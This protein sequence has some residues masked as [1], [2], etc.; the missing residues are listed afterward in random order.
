PK[1][2]RERPAIWPCWRAAPMSSKPFSY[3]ER[4]TRLAPLDPKIWIDYGEAAR[5]AGHSNEASRVFAEAARR[6]HEGSNPLLQAKAIYRQVDLAV[7][8]ADL[9]GARTLSETALTII[10]PLA[11]GDPGNTVWLRELSV[12]YEKIGD[13][14][15][16]QGD[17]AAAFEAYKKDVE[18]M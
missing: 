8:Q 13:A 5:D 3:Y 15:R 12:V 16:A 1:K 4:A 6:A 9:P 7:D 18:I 11:K 2:R 17:I 10:Q 14:L